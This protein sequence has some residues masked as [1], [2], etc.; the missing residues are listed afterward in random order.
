MRRWV[1]A[2]LLAL[3]PLLTWQKKQPGSSIFFGLLD[4]NRNGQIDRNEAR[5]Y[6]EQKIGGTEYDS[7]QELSQAVDLLMKNVDGVDPG[8]TVSLPE[9]DK[10]L[11]KVLEV[12]NTVLMSRHVWGWARVAVACTHERS[13]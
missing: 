8:A 10:H 7:Q 4:K 1:A 3:L 11:D 5:D 13:S 6:I 9:L 2:A 12:R